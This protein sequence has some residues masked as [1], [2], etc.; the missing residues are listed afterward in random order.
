MRGFRKIFVDVLGVE[1]KI[2]LR[3]Y[4]DEPAFKKR[5]IL[6]YCDDIAKEICVCDM[7][8]C[9][10]TMNETMEWCIAFEKESLRHELVHAFLNESGLKASAM[11]Y[12]GAWCKN[13]EMV[14]WM[15]VQFPKMAKAFK[16]LDLL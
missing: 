3:I 13:E 2:R 15:A 10:D 6:A 1:Y 8:S 5:C 14:D 4:E 12:E 11:E 7:M 16:E 9:P